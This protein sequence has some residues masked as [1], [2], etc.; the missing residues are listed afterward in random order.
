M[1]NQLTAHAQ[2]KALVAMFGR[3]VMLALTRKGIEISDAGYEAMPMTISAPLSMG[4]DSTRIVTNSSEVR[5]GPW[6]DDAHIAEPIEGW[7]VRDETG[8]A[9]ASGVY[10]TSEGYGRGQEAVIRE[11]MIILGLR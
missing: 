8:A 3:S 10:L 6:A 1:P 9:L 11:R 7:E 5:F 2:D 4:H